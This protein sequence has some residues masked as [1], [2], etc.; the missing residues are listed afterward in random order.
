MVYHTSIGVCAC[1]QH[2]RSRLWIHAYTEK[3]NVHNFTI[4][5]EM[6]YACKYICKCGC[7][8]SPLSF[9]YKLFKVFHGKKAEIQ[10]NKL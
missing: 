4:S 10:H 5:I 9:L 6:W 8:G 7:I 3:I 2:H 1:A